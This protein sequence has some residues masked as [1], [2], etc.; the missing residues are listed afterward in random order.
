MQEKLRI[1]YTQKR[2]KKLYDEVLIRENLICLANYENSAY[3]A[4]ILEVDYCSTR[5]KVRYVDYGN[6][7]TVDFEE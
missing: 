4:F 6:E 3:R 1:E 5:A 2:L 7:E